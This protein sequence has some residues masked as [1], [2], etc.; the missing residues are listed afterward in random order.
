VGTS[1]TTDG[2]LVTLADTTATAV[3]E[4]S[5]WLLMATGLLFIG[6]MARRRNR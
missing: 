3:P 1:F 2:A 6:A 5:A 4:P